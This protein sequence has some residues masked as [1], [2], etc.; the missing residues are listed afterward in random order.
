MQRR[1]VEVI[2]SRDHHE[3]F[4]RAVNNEKGLRKITKPKFNPQ[5]LEIERRCQTNIVAELNK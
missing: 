5:E 3:N 4:L 1:R 2:N